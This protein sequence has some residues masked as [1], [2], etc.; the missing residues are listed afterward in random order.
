MTPERLKEMWGMNVGSVGIGLPDTFGVKEARECLDE[1][2]SLQQNY[3]ATKNLLVRA[4]KDVLEARARA[5]TAE[6]ELKRIKA[7]LAH[8]IDDASFYSGGPMPVE[9]ISVLR[10][11]EK[12]LQ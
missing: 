8:E 5:E 9:R 1:I 10:E 12:V 4:S 2:A 11:V 6:S 7:W 3:E